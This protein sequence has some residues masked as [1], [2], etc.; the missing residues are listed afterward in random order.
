MTV[1]WSS[2][3]SSVFLSLV[4]KI[5]GAPRHHLHPNCGRGWSMFKPRTDNAGHS[6][7]R[8]LKK[9]AGSLSVGCKYRPWL[10]FSEQRARFCISLWFVKSSK[11]DF[12]LLNIIKFSHNFFLTK[13]NINCFQEKNL[14]IQSN[15][16]RFGATTSHRESVVL[17]VFV[18][19]N[20]N[21]SVL[22]LRSYTSCLNPSYN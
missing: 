12:L 21:L 18:Q 19:H 13:L 6:S 17:G 4:S 11:Y 15:L 7:Q 5:I 20:S 16:W 8:Y 9:N 3:F 10:H 2:F 22:I 14:C 1:G